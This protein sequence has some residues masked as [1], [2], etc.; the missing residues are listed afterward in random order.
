[1]WRR[2]SGRDGTRGA[3]W[4]WRSTLLTDTI[5]DRLITGESE[6]DALPRVMADLATAP[7]DAYVHRIR[8]V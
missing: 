5:L 1:M 3:R 8:Y 2:P 6:F 7:G 4:D